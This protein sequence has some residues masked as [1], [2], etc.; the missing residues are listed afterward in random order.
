MPREHS[1]TEV[2]SLI[3][4]G[5]AGNRKNKDNVIVSSSTAPTKKK[6]STKII[7]FAALVVVQGA[8]ILFFRLSQ[9]N[10]KY[11]YNTASAV[12]VTEAVKL[13]MSAG[14]YWAGTERKMPPLSMFFSYTFCAAAYAINNQLAMWLLLSMGTGMVS[15]G[16]SLT[17]MLTAMTMWSLYPDEKFVRMQG[18]CFVILTMGLVC[19]FA[20]GQNSGNPITPLALAWM[21]FS[22]GVSTFTAVYNSRI[23]QRGGVS[24]H[25]QNM[26]LYSQG[27]VFNIIM[28][29]SGINATGKGASSQG[30]FDGYG[31]FFVIGVLLSQSFMGLVISAVYK[32]GDAIIKGLASSTQVRS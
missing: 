8:H 7:A 17:P 16:K 23:L 9:I 28:Y 10:G 13:F 31:N 15:L 14:L 2:E 22:I 18:I 6:Y 5:E 27:F 26:M 19:L 4:K 29:V 20:P 3:E 25:M 21:L 24:M 12:A 30:F 32:Y 11:A 1:T